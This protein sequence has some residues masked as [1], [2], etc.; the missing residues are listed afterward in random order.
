MTAE[1]TED[2]RRTADRSGQADNGHPRPDSALVKILAGM[3]EHAL[4]RGDAAPSGA[5][6]SPPEATRRNGGSPA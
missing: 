4:A 6:E 2:P 1:K 5:V 3:V